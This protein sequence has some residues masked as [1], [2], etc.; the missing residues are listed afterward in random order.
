M[1]G[2]VQLAVPKRTSPLAT[3][4]GDRAMSPPSSARLRATSTPGSCGSAL[5]NALR[6]P[7]GDELWVQVDVDLAQPARAGVRETVRLAPVDDGQLP[8]LDLPLRLAVIEGGGA[9][10]HDE[11]L[12]I[13]M[14]MQA[15][16]FTGRR[17]DEKHARADASMLLADEIPRDDISGQLVLQEEANPQ[18]DPRVECTGE[19]LPG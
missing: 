7:L 15:W 13:R 10:D 3:L 5:G 4:I 11:D 6:Q 12:D 8:G 17:V 16:S 2:S 14:T 19:E 9:F 18:T 1:V